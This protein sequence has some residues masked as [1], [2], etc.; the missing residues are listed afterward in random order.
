M[1]KKY[2]FLIIILL[3]VFCNNNSQTKNIKYKEFI[4]KMK[5]I[6]YKN[7]KQD[8]ILKCD[9][10]YSYNDSAMYLFGIEFINEDIKILSKKAIKT[11]TSITYLDSVKIY[12]EDSMDIFTD[13]LFVSFS[14]D[15]VKTD[16]SLLIIKDDNT[17]KTKGMLSDINFKKIEFYNPVIVYGED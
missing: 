3:F 15:S 7:N 2:F 1:Q 5:N 16:D 14:N 4:V 9:T 12:L 13:S 6:A 17:M 11:D 8:Y 10:A